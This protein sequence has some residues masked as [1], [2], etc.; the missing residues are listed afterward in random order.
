MRCPFRHSPTV[1]AGLVAGVLLAGVLGAAGDDELPAL[2]DRA[3][4]ALVAGRLDQAQELLAAAAEGGGRLAAF[5]GLAQR[6]AAAGQRRQAL[7]ILLGTATAW[8]R[9]GAAGDAAALLARAVELAPQ[10]AR[11]HALYGEALAKEERHASAAEHLERALALGWDALDS[12]FYLAAA[13]WEIG[14]YADAERQYRAGLEASGGAFPWRHQLGRLLLFQGRDEEA[15][16]LLE[17][18]AAE[19]PSAAD[20]VLDL[21]LA[22]ERSGRGERAL[23][24][25][26]RAVALAPDLARAHYGLAQ[27]LLRRGEAGAAR[28]HLEAFERLYREG[29]ERVRREAL[30]QARRDRAWELLRN[31]DAEAAAE[32][33]RAL[34]DSVEALRGLATALRAAGRPEAAAAALER[35][36]EL[37][38]DDPALRRELAAARLLAGG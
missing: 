30:E 26:R 25:Y 33:F 16:A 12:R 6:L 7:S 15:A 5:D 38:P 24:A 34:G 2:L 20:V 32:R 17:A 37:A 10:E 31:G 36:V 3:A 28:P 4:A 27:L 23:E 35:A 19:R 29:R 13:L 22:C 1:A 8:L 21:A 11:A 9:Q 18:A 14:R